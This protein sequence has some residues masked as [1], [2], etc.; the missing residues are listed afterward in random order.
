MNPQNTPFWSFPADRV[1]Q[2]L[3]SSANG[4][5][6]RDAKQRLIKYGANSLKQQRKS[7]AFGLLLNQFKSPI[8]LILMFA[9]A[10]SMG[11]I[12]RLDRSSDRQ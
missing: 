9:A 1:L 4:L 6:D 11:E 12:L 8:V 5:S 2:Q 10:L 7:S 3:D